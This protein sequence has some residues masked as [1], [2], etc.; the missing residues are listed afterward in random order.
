MTH[1]DPIR[2]LHVCL[3]LVRVEI[4]PPGE[5]YEFFSA[6]TAVNSFPMNG[7]S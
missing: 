5:D 3:K 1:V 2:L 7:A 4:G 6:L